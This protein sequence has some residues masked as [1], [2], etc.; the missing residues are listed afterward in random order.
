[1]PLDIG[2][3]KEFVKKFDKSSKGK[4]KKSMFGKKKD[5]DDKNSKFA[6]FLKK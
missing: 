4:N 5:S 1:M 2:P 3:T 6:K